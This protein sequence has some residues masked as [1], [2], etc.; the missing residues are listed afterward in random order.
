MYNFLG[1]Y[2]PSGGILINR[3][4]L[5]FRFIVNNNIIFVKIEK[6]TRTN[7]LMHAKNWIYWKRQKHI[8][9]YCT[10]FRTMCNIHSINILLLNNKKHMKKLWSWNYFSCRSIKGTNLNLLLTQQMKIEHFLFLLNKKKSKALNPG[11]LLMN[12]FSV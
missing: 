12:V 11:I 4:S 2:F 10:P 3:K 8:K 6:K 1:V 5:Y 9:R 7:L